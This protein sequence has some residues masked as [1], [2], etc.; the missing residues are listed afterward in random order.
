M[1][2]ANIH[3][4]IRICKSFDGKF[5]ADGVEVS[6]DDIDAH[7][8]PALDALQTALRHAETF[9]ELYLSDAFLFSRL[10]EHRAYASAEVSC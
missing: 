6:P 9:G 10:C 4:I 7:V 2:D 1:S 5:R 3:P 8:T